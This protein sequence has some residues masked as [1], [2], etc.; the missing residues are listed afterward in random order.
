[1]ELNGAAGIDDSAEV[2]A[3]RSRVEYAGRCRHKR[4]TLIST[5]LHDTDQSSAR[6]QAR[7]IHS[8]RD[9]LTVNV[10]EV[11]VMIARGDDD[12]MVGAEEVIN[13]SFPPQR[14]PTAL[15][16]VQVTADD[17]QLDA[18][19]DEQRVGLLGG[20]TQVSVRDVA[21]RQVTRH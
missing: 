4:Q 18:F 1:M 6:R 14:T 3:L 17:S 13:L 12:G 2:A 7:S 21:D 10:P 9:T 5:S 19:T 16:V 15:R 11:V 20:V 8:C